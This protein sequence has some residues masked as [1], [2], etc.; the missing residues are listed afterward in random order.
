MR[1]TRPFLRGLLAA[2]LLAAGLALPAAAQDTPAGT[3]VPFVDPEGITRGTIMVK[4]VADPFTEFDPSY[5]AEQ[6]TRYVGMIVVFTASDEETFEANAS[7]F[8]LRDETGRLW[9]PA[10]LPRPADAK[11]PD[12]QSQTLAPGNRISGFL[13]FAIPEGVAADEILYLPDYEHVL[14]IADLLPGGGNPVGTPYTYT[15]EDGAIADVNAVLADP[16][17]EYSEGYDPEEG[18]RW[19]GAAYGFENTGELPFPAWPSEI[20]LRDASG[21]IYSATYLSRPEGYVLADA[22][23][24]VL[25]PG[26][27]IT[28]FLA[29]SLP[30]DAEIVAIDYATEGNRRVTIG[31]LRA[32]G[33]PLPGTDEPAAPEASPGTSQ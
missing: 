13:G 7:G 32:E 6:G 25:S 19:V 27:R 3:E 30:A 24:Q 9:Y 10:W 2:S 5:P 12:A 26:D 21:R 4:D 29:Y 14:V 18:M 22:E 1:R 11:I 23:S 17:T 8:V 28:G 15:R 20:Y 33:G 31:D 16:F